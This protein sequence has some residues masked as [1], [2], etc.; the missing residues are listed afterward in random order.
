VEKNSDAC[1]WIRVSSDEQSKGYSPDAQERLLEE[2]AAKNKYRV[3][4]KFKI[5]ESAKTS[6]NRKQFKELISFIKENKVGNLVALAEDR[7]TRNYTDLGILQN[8]IDQDGLNVV[9]ADSGRSVNRDSP[10]EHRFLF[11]LMGLLAETE[12]RNRSKKVKQGMNEKAKQ[13]I[14]PRWA[15]LGFRNIRDPKDPEGKR[16]II[17]KD[18]EAA[19]LVKRLLELYARGG[20]S[21][22]TIQ[23]EA[24]R[25][26]LKSR[27]TSKYPERV[28]SDHAVEV[29][30]RNRFYYGEVVWSG[31][32][33]PS[34]CETLISRERS[35]ER[36][37]G[38]EC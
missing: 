37:V 32:I 28:L 5:S 33:Y 29:I 31:E 21:L 30:L 10:G 8:L 11:S 16:R 35:E 2:V 4:R 6:S 19:P 20:Q 25:I 17:V 22:R 24:A 23:E 12:N 7:L 38:K 36:R 34:K 14:L 13:G 26:G 18:K 1:L 3:V 27:R 15:P 9:L